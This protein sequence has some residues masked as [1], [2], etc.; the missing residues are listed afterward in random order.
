M[1]NHPRFEL[2]GHL[3]ELSMH[4]MPL[5]ASLGPCSTFDDTVDRP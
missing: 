1:D 4:G 2:T 3:F 5:V